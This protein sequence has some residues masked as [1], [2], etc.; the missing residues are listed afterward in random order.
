MQHEPVSKRYGDPIEVEVAGGLPLAFVWRG[1]RYDVDQYL[2][3]WLEAPAAVR[4]PDV[5]FH[6]VLARPAGLTATGDLD[7]DGFGSPL[8]AVYDLAQENTWRLARVWD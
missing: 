7:P 4:A 5:R 8:G 6:R 2:S 3:S 1:R